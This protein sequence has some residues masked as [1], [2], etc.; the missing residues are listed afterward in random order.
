GRT[1]VFVGLPADG[2]RLERIDLDPARFR[3]AVPPLLDRPEAEPLRLREPLQSRPY[4]P[5]R[6]MWPHTWGFASYP[7][8]FGQVIALN[9]A[10]GDIV[11]YHSWAFSVGL[12]LARAD[13]V[14]VAVSYSYD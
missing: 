6:T 13:D 8:A 5:L 14:G 12:S 4:N 3:P 9:F 10:G 11:G 2:Y 7:D 1:G